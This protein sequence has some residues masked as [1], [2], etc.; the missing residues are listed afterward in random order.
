MNT[1]KWLTKL[2]NAIARE[3]SIMNDIDF[4]DIIKLVYLDLQCKR[5]LYSDSQMD[6]V[7]TLFGG[8]L[9]KLREA[10]ERRNP[11][12]A[13]RELDTLVSYLGVIPDTDHAADF[14]E[15]ANMDHLLLEHIRNRTVYVVGDSH[16]NFFSGNESLAFIPVGNDI[17]TSEQ[18]G[19]LPFSVFHM[20]PCLAYNSNFYNTSTRFREKLDYLLE[21]V[22]KP[23]EYIMFVMGEIDIRAH[24]FKE[25][26]AKGKKYE[27]IVDDILENYLV[28]MKGVINKGYNVLCFG[29]IASQSEDTPMD[30]M[31]VRYGSEVE[32][33]TATE[34][35]TNKIN[36][37]CLENNIGFLSI[38]NKMITSDYHTRTEYL[39]EDGCHLSQSALNLVIDEV[40]LKLPLK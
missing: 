19:G 10:I 18:I 34:Y 27:E 23:G 30:D 28:M 2:D 25:C 33:N 1:R 31:F 5:Q 11:I 16:V 6:L 26:K 12:A 29:P 13:H 32:R 20:G 7:K 37:L 8:I 24:V 22:I 14:V 35:F 15:R 9:D 4:D 36:H 3:P 38:F 21:S 17:N 39:C 40:N